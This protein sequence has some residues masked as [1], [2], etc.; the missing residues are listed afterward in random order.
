MTRL[1]PVRNCV[2]FGAMLLALTSWA[3]AQAFDAVRLYSAPRGQN[4]GIAGAVVLSGPAYLGADRRRSQLKPRA[5]G[6]IVALV[7]ALSG[8]L[9]A[10]AVGTPLPRLAPLPTDTTSAADQT[11][12]LVLTRVVLDPSK[13]AEFDRQNNRVMAGMGQH[14]GLLGYAARKQ[15]FGNQGWTMSVWAN[16]EARAAF[17]RSPVHREA[18]AKSMPALVSVELKR[19]TLPRKDLPTDWDAVRRLLADPEGLRNYWE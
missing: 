14:P 19:L 1:H 12:V 15:L 7:A 8:L 9:N 16:D 2:V 13:R 10:C 4:L 11:V 3:R 18:I 6:L 17:V 5:G